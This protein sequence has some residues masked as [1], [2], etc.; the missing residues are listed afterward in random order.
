[1]N[2]LSE[3]QKRINSFKYYTDYTLECA[4]IC[5]KIALIINWKVK[6]GICRHHIGICE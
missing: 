1:M 2:P 4:A 5:L 3:D 6:T